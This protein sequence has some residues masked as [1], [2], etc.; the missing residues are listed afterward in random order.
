MSTR[1]IIVI[2]GDGKHGTAQTIRLYKH[3]DGYPTG[4]LPIIAEALTKAKEQCKETNE[5]FQIDNPRTPSV[6]QVTGLL[7]GRKGA[8]RETWSSNACYYR[9]HF[10][11]EAT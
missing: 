3:S 8:W 10:G 6:E 4:N 11:S 9:S 2:T 1:S 7:K 5:R